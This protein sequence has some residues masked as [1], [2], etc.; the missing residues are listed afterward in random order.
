MA[1][2]VYIKRF[3]IFNFLENFLYIDPIVSG[4]LST[5]AFE[6]STM[7]GGG[8]HYN[9][10]F[11]LFNITRPNVDNAFQQPQQTVQPNGVNMVNYQA[12][13]GWSYTLAA[14]DGSSG[15]FFRHIEVG[16][17]SWASGQHTASGGIVDRPPLGG[18]SI[19]G[20]LSVANHAG[21]SALNP[22]GVQASFTAQGDA[23]NLVNNSTLSLT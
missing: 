7:E 17:P 18:T 1:T 9:D 22:D 12:L 20:S 15:S 11:G 19:G 14:A 4:A 23:G 6:S 21:W 5:C 3:F 16:G 2:N 10:Q 8:N 13:V